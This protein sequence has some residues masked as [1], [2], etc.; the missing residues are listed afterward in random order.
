MDDLLRP[1]EATPQGAGIF[2]D[3]DGSLSEIV[4]DPS[5]ARPYPGVPEVL[6]QLAERYAV[7]AI[8]SGRSAHQLFEWLGTGVEIWGVHGAERVRDG[9]VVL[10]ERAERYRA[11]MQRVIEE[12]RERVE[13]LP[14]DGFLVEDKTIMVGLHYRMVE[15]MEQGRVLLESVVDE[16]AHAHGLSRASGRA[17]FELRPAEEFSKAQVVLDRA[18]E[19]KLRS[20]LFVGDDAVDIPAFEALDRL[21]TEGVATVR[22]AVRSDE[23][24]PEL[25][26][27]ADIV[28][29]GPRG[30]LEF[31]EGLANPVE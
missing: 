28:V 16:L 9:Q 17:S 14:M 2:L 29:P 18:H 23:A 25:I 3:F 30:A 5:N 10:S 21:A 15:D 31:L 4:P 22:V 6:K 8:I 7:V 11:F 12:A 1:F 13:Q 24:P 19:A 27:K 26:E 20:A